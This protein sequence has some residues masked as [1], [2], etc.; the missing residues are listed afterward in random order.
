[1]EAAGWAPTSRTAFSDDC[2]SGRVWLGFGLGAVIRAAYFLSLVLVSLQSTQVNHVAPVRERGIVTG[3]ML[4]SVVLR[5]GAARQRL[6]R[7]GIIVPGVTPL[8]LAS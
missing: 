5:E 3:T 4:G 7:A 1:M 6:A 8:S 2:S